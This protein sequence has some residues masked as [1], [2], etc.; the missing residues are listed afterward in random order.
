MS[1][2]TED[3]IKIPFGEKYLDAVI[4]VPGASNPVRHGVILTHGAGGDMN[5]PHLAFLKSHE[6][7]KISSVFLAGRSMGSRA[8][9]SVMR[10]ACENDNEFIQ[11][12]IC[13]S[14]PLH[15]ANS[16]A[17]LRDEDILSLTKPVLFVSG[18]SDEMCDQTLLKNVVSKMKV[19][20]QIHWIKNANHGMAVK[21]ETM[22][23]VMTEINTHVFSWIQKTVDNL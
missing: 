6:E 2:Y 3:R 9:A 7:H 16:K 21:G 19:P 11:G 22:E 10:E 12:L 14:Y 23:D 5:F 18:S 4:C 8:A 20:A 15:P 17:K 1:E 13:L